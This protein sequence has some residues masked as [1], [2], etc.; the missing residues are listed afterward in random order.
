MELILKN[1]RVFRKTIE[2]SW[3][4]HQ[5]TQDAFTKLIDSVK[6]LKIPDDLKKFKKDNIYTLYK[7]YDTILGDY[8]FLFI[9]VKFKDNIRGVLDSLYNK[10]Q[11][12][13]STYFNRIP[14]T[15]FNEFDVF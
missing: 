11:I 7:L 10:L 15:V 5:D 4:Y 1:I 13:P 12:N 8:S 9:P 2:E 14:T 3:W 6:K